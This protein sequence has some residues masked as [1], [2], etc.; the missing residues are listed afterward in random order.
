[1]ELNEVPTSNAK[2]SLV[3]VPVYG[4]CSNA[5]IGIRVGVKDGHLALS[6]WPKPK[7]CCIHDEVHFRCP[8]WVGG[9]RPHVTRDDRPFPKSPIGW[10]CVPRSVLALTTNAC[11]GAV[12]VEERLR[13]SR[14]G[15]NFLKE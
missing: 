10:I 6:G 1:M 3:D 2:Q 8:R 12:W 13:A 15:A 11:A 7:T 4:C 9:P 5:P 14:S